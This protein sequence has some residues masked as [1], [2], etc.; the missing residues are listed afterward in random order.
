LNA[1]FLLYEI[2]S[3]AYFYCGRLIVF[4]SSFAQSTKI[5][6]D[7]DAV[8]KQA[9]DYYQQQYY[10]LAYPLFKDIYYHPVNGNF[11][12]T[13]QSEAKYYYIVC[14]LQLDDSAAA[15]LATEYIN[16][17]NN[18]PRIQA[19]GFY[20]GEYYFRR[21]DLADALAYYNKSSID[22]LNNDEVADLKFH[23]GYILFT[24]QQFNEAK[25]LLDAVRQLKNNANYI[26][27]NYYYGFIA[28]SQKDYNEALKSFTIAESS[29]TYNNIVPFYIAEIYYF[30]GDKDKAL[31]YAEAKIKQG[32]QF[33]DLQ[34]KQLAGHLWFDKKAY[35]QAL[36]YLKEYVAKTDKVKR[37]DLYELSYCYYATGNWQESI[38]GFKQLG[39]K[40]DSL[41]QNSMYLLADA[42]LKTGDKP[43]ARNAFL[44]CATNNSNDIQK[45]VSSFNYAKL[46][47]ELGFTDIALKSLQHF[48]ATYPKSTYL[49]EA[50][51]LTISVLANTSNYKDALT[52]FES[53]DVKTATAQKYIL[54]FYMVVQLK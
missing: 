47:Y 17:D 4:F 28:F 20:L 12:A 19:L 49:L 41:A 31:A 7:P 5:N 52:L 54:K 53:L 23:K 26:D 18:I 33:Y 21:K 16:L 2:Q 29:P 22:N 15:A 44:F 36:P 8:F 3:T 14:G 35:A 39:G 45:E 46:S 13:I 24:M 25:P 48:M 9:K 1:L 30:M 10:S 42:Y 32:N 6:N 40:E 37:E 50:K 38:T 11:P 51:E 27:A 34:L 43:S